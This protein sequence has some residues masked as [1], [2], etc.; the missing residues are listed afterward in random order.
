[1]GTKRYT[2]TLYDSY[3]IM[4]RQNLKNYSVS[5]IVAEALDH[6]QRSWW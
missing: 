6:I 4:P 2:E 5:S 1:M 3:N